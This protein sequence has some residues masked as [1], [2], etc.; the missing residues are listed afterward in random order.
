M[1]DNTNSL[2]TGRKVK[3]KQSNDQKKT[4]NRT[5]NDLQNITLQTK[6]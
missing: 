2:I 3:D 4:E 5:N 6:D 1:F